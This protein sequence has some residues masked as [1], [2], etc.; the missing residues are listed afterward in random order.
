MN[1]LITDFQPTDDPN[2]EPV[3]YRDSLIRPVLNVSSSFMNGGS[4]TRLFIM[5]VGQFVS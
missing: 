4:C 1:Y 3:F 2:S 5:G